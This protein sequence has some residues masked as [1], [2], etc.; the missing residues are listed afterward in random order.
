MD[1]VKAICRCKKLSE[2]EPV[3]AIKEKP[4]ES[5]GF[6]TWIITIVL[7]VATAGGWL[8]IV[9]G[10]VLGGYFLAPTYRCQYCKSNIEKKQFRA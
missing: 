10:W 3:L 4:L 5:W 8:P 9:I 1:A 6:F 7:V 2:A